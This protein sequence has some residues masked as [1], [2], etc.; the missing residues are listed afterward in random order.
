MNDLTTIKLDFV[1]DNLWQFNLAIAF[2]MFGVSLTLKPDSF[3]PIFHRPKNLFVGLLSQ[4]VLLPMVTVVLIYLFNPLPGLALGMLLVASCPGGN[5]SNFFTQQALGNVAL[6]V[7]L[8]A[9]VS[10]VSGVIT[11]LNFDFWARIYYGESFKISVD[12]FGIAETIF[13]SLALPLFIGMF[14][15][16]RFPV[17]AKRIVKPV[18]TL[19]VILLATIILLAFYKNFDTFKQY[20]HYII[21]IV[22]AHN[23]SALLVGYFTARVFR[24]PA[25]D[26]RTI[27]IETGIQNSALALLIIFGFFN[28]NGAMALIAAWWGIWHLISGFV[29]SLIFSRMARKGSR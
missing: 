16:S 25:I 23:L 13:L 5:V 2:I 7:S 21:F 11:P 28:S 6:S 10:V 12:Y 8:T 18:K 29:A 15:A 24:L 14:T 17:I 9:I 4:V 27:S 19:S 1:E 3:K 26:Q 22:F 20:Y